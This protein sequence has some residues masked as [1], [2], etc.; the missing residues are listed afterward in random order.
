MIYPTDSIIQPLNNWGQG[1]S[2]IDSFPLGALEVGLL[3]CLNLGEMDPC[4]LPDLRRSAVLGGVL[5]LTFC[6]SAEILFGSGR[7]PP[8]P[9]T[10]P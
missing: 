7:I 10:T 2:Q 6:L 5:E 1:S 9:Q 8:W 3:V 4:N